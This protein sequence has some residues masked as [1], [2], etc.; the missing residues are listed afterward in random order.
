MYGK[1]AAAA[2]AVLFAAMSATGAAAQ[3]SGSAVKT[4]KC[5]F[6][7]APGFEFPGPYFVYFDIDSTAVKPEYRAELRKAVED[8]RAVYVQQ[9]C[10]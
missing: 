5:I 6:K 3:S 4:G 10:L 9:I 2:T 8:A 1:I 7:R